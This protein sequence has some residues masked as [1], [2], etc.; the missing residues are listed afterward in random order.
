MLFHM[1]VD[2]VESACIIVSKLPA[3]SVY[4]FAHLCSH[5]CNRLSY[6]CKSWATD[7]SAG[8]KLIGLACIPE[9][10]FSCEATHNI[11]ATNRVC[12]TQHSYCQHSSSHQSSLPSL[13]TDPFYGLMSASPRR[14]SML[15]LCLDLAD[16]NEC[17][18]FGVDFR[19]DLLSTFCSG[20]L[21][22]PPIWPC[23]TRSF[24]TTKRPLS[25]SGPSSSS[26]SCWD[27]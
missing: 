14:S 24:C 9:I 12:F 1:V 17:V 7:A 15:C 11:I 8:T 26:A 18:R 2:H 13:F 21:F 5:C 16:R 6:S 22:A 3:R 27:Q 10:V 25:S 4:I 23:I 20:I 19:C